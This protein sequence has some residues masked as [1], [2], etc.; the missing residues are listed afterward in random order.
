MEF[1]NEKHSSEHT[2]KAVL[3]EPRKCLG[4]SGANQIKYVEQMGAR[5]CTNKWYSRTGA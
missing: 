1:I 4:N 2:Q 3:R 5:L